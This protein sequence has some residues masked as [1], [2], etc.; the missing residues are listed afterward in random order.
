MPAQL[1]IVSSSR[2]VLSPSGFGTT[3]PLRQAGKEIAHAM[4]DGRGINQ[5]IAQPNEGQVQMV[6]LG[7][8]VSKYFLLQTIRLAQLAFHAIARHSMLQMALRHAQEHLHGH[9]VIL[10]TVIETIDHTNRKGRQRTAAP[11]AEET[12]YLQLAD[13]MLFLAVCLPAV[14]F[15][16][17]IYFGL[18]ASLNYSCTL[19]SRFR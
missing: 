16:G 5:I 12:V 17:V 15:V 9:R 10:R 18:F 19:F 8:R 6:S 1:P 2:Y 4:V 11:F 13:D 7:Q 3:Q 14:I